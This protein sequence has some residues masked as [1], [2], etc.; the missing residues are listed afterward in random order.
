MSMIKSFEEFIT[1][2][3]NKDYEFIAKR[4]VALEKDFFRELRSHVEYWFLYDSL[5]KDYTL[6]AA[7]E[8]ERACVAWAEDKQ[9]DPQFQYKI[10]FAEVESLADIEKIEHV[11]CIIH[12][13]ELETM[14]IVKTMEVKIS[15]KHLNSDFLYETLLKMK[16]RIITPPKNKEELK[17]FKKREKRRLGDN[18]Y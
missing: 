1:E 14:K 17:K 5:S 18:I 12:I 3:E 11:L 7:E 2:K 8:E 13:Y 16:K 6:Q 15:L 9:E 10:K 4:S